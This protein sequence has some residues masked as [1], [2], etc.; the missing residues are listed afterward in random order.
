MIDLHIHSTYSD[1][2]KKVEEL[3]EILKKKRAELFAIT[4]HDNMD[5]IKILETIPNI[6]YIPGV[7]MS[8]IDNGIKMHILGYGIEYDSSLRDTCEFVKKTRKDLTLEIVGDLIKRGYIFSADDMNYFYN[9]ESSC[10]GKVEISKILV[11]NGYA[12]SVSE[13]FNGILG[14]YKIGPKFRRTAEEIIGEIKMCNGIA[15]LAHPFEMVHKQNAD[16]DSVIDIL[17]H[18][19]LDG[20]EAFT[21]AH[22]REEQEYIY[23]LCKRRNLLIS[24]G[25]DYHGP[26]TKPNIE[27]GDC[28]KGG[29]ISER[30]KEKRIKH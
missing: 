15:V 20:V 24:G 11:K 5:S 2:D 16:V 18:Y 7:E 22:T 26:L 27:I 21:T 3:I 14:K 1:G 19:G 28:V 29:L 12:S 8:A 9:N 30:V 23:E 6:T 4:D 10:L 25:S 17:T 13:A